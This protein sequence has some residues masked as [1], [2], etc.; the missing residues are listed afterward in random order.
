VNQTPCTNGDLARINGPQG[1]AQGDIIEI[2]G[3]VLDQTG[4]PVCGARMLIWQ[5]NSF[6][7]YTHPSDSN[8]APLDPN[9]CGFAELRSDGEGAYRIRTVRPGAYPTAS[10]EMRSPHLH[11]EVLGRFERLVTQ[12]YFPG[13]PLNERDR[14]LS[15]SLRADLL[16]ARTISSAAAAQAFRFNIVLARG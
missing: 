1:R 13:V 3:C 10:G 16:I 11:F 8:P 6:G 2:T 5:A 14:F 4:Q 12:M 15:S 9:F 7:R